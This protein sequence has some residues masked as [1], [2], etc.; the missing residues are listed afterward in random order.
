MRHAE[1][2]PITV[3]LAVSIQANQDLVRIPGRYVERRPGVSEVKA[4]E[5]LPIADARAEPLFCERPKHRHMR[6]QPRRHFAGRL[7][8]D[9]RCARHGTESLAILSQGRDDV[10]VEDL[11]KGFEVGATRRF[12]AQNLHKQ[13]SPIVIALPSAIHQHIVRFLQA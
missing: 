12:P 5:M 6:R 3:G 9:G 4:P 7:A 8:M 13:L 1:Q 10:L 11:G 2:R